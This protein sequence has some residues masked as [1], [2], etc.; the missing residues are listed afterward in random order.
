[1]NNGSWTLRTFVGL[2]F[3]FLLLPLVAVVVSSFASTPVMVFPPSGFTTQWYGQIPGEFY[4]AAWTSLIVATGTAVLSVL[5]GTPTALGLARGELPGHATINALMLSPL[6]VPTLVIAVAAFQF[7]KVVWQMSGVA[8]DDTI[9]GLILAQSAFTIPFVLRSVIAGHANFDR[10]LEEASQ[11]LGATPWQTFRRVT[12]PLLA[13]GIASGAIFAF[14]M[15]FDDLPVALFLS[16]GS[17]TTLPV[18][19]FTSIEF[20]LDIWIM[21]VA[22]MVIGVSLVLM[23]ILDRTIGCDK[24][25]GATRA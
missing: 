24:F 17:V 5:V 18:K 16:G 11:N 23:V 12:L 20:S 25:V 8:L 3:A 2:V 1:M 19:L 7:T 9:P 22:S 21:A 14:L 4:Q 6:M 13:P 15:S 10:T